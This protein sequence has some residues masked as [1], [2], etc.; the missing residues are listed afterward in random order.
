[1]LGLLAFLRLTE[2]AALDVRALQAIQRVRS[3]WRD[4]VPEGA[5]YFPAPNAW[6][7]V[8]IV[9][10]TGER[11]GLFR[12]TLTIAASVG[13]VNSLWLAA[14]VGFAL[15][16]LGLPPA[17]AVVIGVVVGIA[18]VTVLFRHQ[19]RRIGHVVGAELPSSV[20]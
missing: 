12:A 20:P 14:G 17:G 4:L 2:L 19:T 15:A 16:D 13:L 9:L 6:Q 8:D 10:D 5:Q 7:A 11:R 1:M 18:I 3:Y